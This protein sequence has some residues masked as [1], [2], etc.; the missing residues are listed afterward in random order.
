MFNDCYRHRRVLVTGHT[1]FK[2]S[3]LSFWLQLLGAEICGI[4][5]PVQEQPNHHSLLNMSFRS[6]FCDIGNAEALQKLLNDF[7]PELIFHLA[8]QSLVRRSYRNPVETFA[9]NVLGSAKLLEACR[10]CDSLRAVLVVSS[11]K[12]YENREWVWG[13]RENEAMG[14]YDPY[15]ASKGC[16]EL[17]VS[18]WRR[19]FFHPDEFGR[20]HQVLLA[21]VRS[22]NVIGGG[23][24]AE[25]RLIPDLMKAAAA[26]QSV[27]LRN[28]QALRPWQHV[29]EPLSGYLLLGQHLLAGKMEFAEAWNFGPASQETL[30]VAEVAQG[31]SACWPDIAAITQPQMDALHEAE[32]LRLDCSKANS[33]LKWHPVWNAKETIQRTADWYRRFYREK[34]LG[35]AD[36]LAAYCHDAKKQDLIW[37]K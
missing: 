24:W 27:E 31:L 12:C 19:S 18:S 35:T 33:Q 32:L 7:Q 4:A 6:E 5:L 20:R 36:D 30:S 16:T 21:S 11:D 17:L 26:K 9:T 2:G 29:L 1:G 28:P 34:H 23:D 22:G 15:S 13:Y 3:W 14:G 8:A 25:D 10:H 37:S